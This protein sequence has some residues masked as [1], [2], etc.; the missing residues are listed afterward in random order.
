MQTLNEV[1]SKYPYIL[2]VME[3]AAIAA[4][5]DIMEVYAKDEIDTEVETA[6]QGASS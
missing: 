3:E 5:N 2:K 6:L 1:I 4:G